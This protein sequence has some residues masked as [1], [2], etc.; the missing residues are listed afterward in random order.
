M[1]FG[2][3]VQCDE[4]ITQLAKTVSASAIR[5]MFQFAI[6]GGR[7]EIRRIHRISPRWRFPF[8]LCRR[9]C[10]QGRAGYHYEQQRKFPDGGGEGIKEFQGH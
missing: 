7:F 10:C 4:E 6:A 9:V 8:A 3:P 5:N 2:M 1:I